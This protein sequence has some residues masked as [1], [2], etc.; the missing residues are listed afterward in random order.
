MGE[1][2]VRDSA[3]G[4]VVGYLY[5]IFGLGWGFTVCLLCACRELCEFFFF[6]FF[7]F[8]FYYLS[9]SLFFLFLLE[10]EEGPRGFAIRKGLTWKLL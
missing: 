9:L 7:F 8:S 5:G 10:A 2:C 6:L 1:I 4:E 3:E